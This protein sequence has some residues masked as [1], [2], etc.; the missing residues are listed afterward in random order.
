[1]L[2]EA[3]NKMQSHF[4]SLW[5]KILVKDFS[6]SAVLKTILWKVALSLHKSKDK[7][8]ILRGN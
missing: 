2:V 7:K 8:G 6:G 3:D 5:D 4:Y 1:M